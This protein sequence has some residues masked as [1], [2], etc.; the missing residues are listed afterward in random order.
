MYSYMT[1]GCT[2]RLLQTLIVKCT[3][4]SIAILILMGPYSWKVW[5]GIKFGDLA[6]QFA[7]AKL[8]STSASYL[9][10]YVW[11][12]LTELPNLN[13]SIFLQWRFRTQPP[14]LIPANISVYTV[15]SLARFMREVRRVK[16]ARLSSVAQFEACKPMDQQWLWLSASIATSATVTLGP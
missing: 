15:A 4:L 13:P 2:I 3:L 7:T 8:N 12:S 14:N 16:L 6:V 11:G 10:I 9:H 1:V 5:Q